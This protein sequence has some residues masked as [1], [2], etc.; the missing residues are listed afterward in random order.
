MRIKRL[1][2]IASYGRYSGDNYGAHCLVVDIGP[3]TVWFSYRTPVAFHLDGQS[4]VVRKNCW[5]PTTG[6]HLNWIDGGNKKDRVTE[7][8]F[9]RL[10]GEQVAVL[11]ADEP[12]E[13]KGLLAEVFA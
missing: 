1:P 9:E 6:K 12:E 11:F 3:L 13:V 4:R 10:W 7:E 5:G 8:E 2:K